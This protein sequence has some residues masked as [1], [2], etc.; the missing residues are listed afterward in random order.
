MG[1][2][3]VFGGISSFASQGNAFVCPNRKAP[4]SCL[5][6]FKSIQKLEQGRRRVKEREEIV[7]VNF[8]TSSTS[9][10]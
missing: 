3:V 2:W 1:R 9:F 8:V 7:V 10:K 5:D 6:Y 4:H